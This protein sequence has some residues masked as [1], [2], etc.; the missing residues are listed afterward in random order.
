MCTTVAAVAAGFVVL[1]LTLLVGLA[2][3]RPT[4]A[5]IPDALRLLPDTVV[6]LRRLAADRELPRGVRIRL[7]LL[8]VYLIL[9]IDLVP[10]FI[11]V[12]GYADDAII[13][14]VTLRSVARRAGTHALDKHWPGTPDGLQV[15]RRLAGVPDRPGN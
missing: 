1:W 3:I 6:L 14:A 9:P 15:V 2:V 10:D 5:S 8:L 4:D 12:L 13:V 7:A 11:P